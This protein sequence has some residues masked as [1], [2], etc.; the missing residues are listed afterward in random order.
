VWAWLSLKAVAWAH[1]ERAHG[2]SGGQAELKLSKRA[3][4]GLAW[5]WATAFEGEFTKVAYYS[6]QTCQNNLDT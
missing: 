1:P 4:L 2:L 6:M 3:W 5:A